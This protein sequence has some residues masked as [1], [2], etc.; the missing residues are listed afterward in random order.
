MGESQKLTHLCKFSEQIEIYQAAST[1]IILIVSGPRLAILIKP[2]VF[3]N[4]FISYMCLVT[5]MKE[6]KKD[7]INMQLCPTASV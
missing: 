1:N 4:I 2:H 5:P 6:G 3:L 7:V